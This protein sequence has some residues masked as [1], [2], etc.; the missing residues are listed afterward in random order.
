MGFIPAE[1]CAREALAG[2]ERNR[3]MVAF[4]APVRVLWR[5]Y[6]LAPSVMLRLS[7]LTIEKSP[8]LNRK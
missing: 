1:R 7:Q 5:L 8:L 4:P 6:R 2:V 3:A